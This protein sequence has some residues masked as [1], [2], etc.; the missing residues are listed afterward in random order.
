MIDLNKSNLNT[1]LYKLSK[2]KF[3]LL[4]KRKK[5]IFFIIKKITYKKI[6][7]LLSKD[8][9]PKAINLIKSET[10]LGFIKSF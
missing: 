5:V 10:I 2:F 4:L 3:I 9:N 1:N 6:I 8:N 7:F